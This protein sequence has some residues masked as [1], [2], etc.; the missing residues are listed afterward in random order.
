M[1]PQY[2]TCFTAPYWH[3]TY[4]GVFQIL[5]IYIPPGLSHT[6]PNTAKQMIQKSEPL[7][8]MHANM[9]LSCSDNMRTHQQI[10][11][12][13][14]QSS[15]RRDHEAQLLLLCSFTKM[16]QNFQSEAWFLVSSTTNII[17]LLWFSP[18]KVKGHSQCKHAITGTE[19]EKRYSCTNSWPW[20]QT[21][22]GV[23][24]PHTANLSPRKRP[25]AQ[26]RGG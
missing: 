16:W 18:S 13:T 2:G 21:V 26:Y 25:G 10:T 8:H 9:W 17:T 20:L 4:W 12:P 15:V 7:L 19:W 11:R 3:I 6:V 22:R 1:S 24:T 23:V 14:A 5:K